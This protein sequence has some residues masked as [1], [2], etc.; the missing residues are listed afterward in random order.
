[1]NR[2]PFSLVPA[3]G[4]FIVSFILLTLPGSDI[5]QED[6][7]DKI[8]F[9]KWVHIGMFGILTV[10]WCRSLSLIR[11]NFDSK[12]LKQAFIIIGLIGLGYGVAMEFV[13]KYFIPNR[14]FD[15]SDMAADGIGC[16]LGVIFS[17][18]KYIKK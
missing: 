3:I 16:L 15:I 13:Q 18:R 4:W 10:L 5:P 2:A 17:T 12:K 1:L 6:W 8:W 11:P 7:L 9:D 14:S